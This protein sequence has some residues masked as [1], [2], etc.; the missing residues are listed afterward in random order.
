MRYAAYL[1]LATLVGISSLRA[2]T[3][4]PQSTAPVQRGPDGE[5]RT[6]VPGVE[7]LPLPGMPFT[8]RGHTTFTRSADGGVSLTSYLEA[9]VGRDSQGRVYRERHHFGPADVNPQKTLYESYVLDPIA[10]TRTA[11]YYPTRRCTITSYHPTL[12]FAVLP[13][14]PYD[15]GQRFLTRE[16][17]GNQTMEDLPVIGTREITTYAAGVIGNDQPV[18]STREFWYSTDLKTNLAVTRK[19]P[20]EG[21]VVVHLSIYSRAEPDPA[22]FAT[23]PA[24][25][26]QDDRQLTATPPTDR[27]SLRGPR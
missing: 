4:P 23:P 5:I 24:F 26:V 22:I 11:C 13:A 6:S 14:G 9:N 15:Q 27:P 3:G 7:V 10:H 1:L 21:N 25:T 16:T 12:S 19:D 8:G 2:Q 18:T 20:R 17:L